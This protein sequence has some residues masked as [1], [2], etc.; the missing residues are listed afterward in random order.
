MIYLF[1]FLIIFYIFNFSSI[2]LLY[3]PKNKQNINSVILAMKC[4]FYALIL[5]SPRLCR[6]DWVTCEP[7]E[8]DWCFILMRTGSKALRK[9]EP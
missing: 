6:D 9:K 8:R 7:M 3:T 2:K 4:Q 5:R 1:L